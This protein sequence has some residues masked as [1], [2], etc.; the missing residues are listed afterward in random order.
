MNCK[1]CLV[2]FTLLLALALP[3]QDAAGN[4]GR[5]KMKKIMLIA[6]VFPF[7]LGAQTVNLV[8]NGEGRPVP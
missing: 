3:A 8:K 2:I 1:R 7:C 4:K 6:L 5:M